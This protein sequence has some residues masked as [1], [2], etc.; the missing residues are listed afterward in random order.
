[1]SVNVPVAL[2]LHEFV[3]VDEAAETGVVAAPRASTP[4]TRA[5]AATTL[6]RRFKEFISTVLP[7]VSVEQNSGAAVAPPVTIA[8]SAGSGDK[9]IPWGHV[10]WPVVA[11]TDAPNPTT[12]GGGIT[13]SVALPPP[14]PHA[15]LP[16]SGGFSSVRPNSPERRTAEGRTN[17][18]CRSHDPPVSSGRELCSPA[19]TN[20]G[21]AEGS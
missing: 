18:S 1:M 7:T 21:C 20:R 10:R 3:F 13:P 11:A 2:L 16:N 8:S 4:A 6:M 15:S 5:K 14:P 12:L 19:T 9:V 17:Q